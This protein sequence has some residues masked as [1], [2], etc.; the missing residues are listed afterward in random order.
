M[1]RLNADPEVVR[2]TGDSAF[3][4]LSEA[5]AVVRALEQQWA[6]HRLGRLVVVDRVSGERLGW[7]GLKWHASEAGVDLGFRL[8]RSV[9]GLGY[10]T[11]AGAACLGEA[12]RRGLR[13]FANA[14]PANVGS[15]RVLAKLGFRPTERVDEDGFMRFVR[16][17]AG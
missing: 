9:W 7:C 12:D 8:L 6:E 1:L 11:E 4:A 13:V 14:M 10:A 3:G 17:R 2:Y 16:E 15:V 5:E